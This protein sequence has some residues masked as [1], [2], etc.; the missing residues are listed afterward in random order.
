[1]FKKGSDQSKIYI[2]S[3]FEK[4]IKELDTRETSKYSG[5]D[6]SHD[7]QHKNEK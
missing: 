3:P 1:M 5:I 4:D 7:I 6:E 2:G